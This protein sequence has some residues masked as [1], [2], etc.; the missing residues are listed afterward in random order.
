[1]TFKRFLSFCARAAK[2]VLIVLLA[3]ALHSSQGL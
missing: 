2:L 1:M 3:L